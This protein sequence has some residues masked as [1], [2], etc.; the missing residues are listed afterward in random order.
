M[1]HAAETKK[2]S[3]SRKTQKNSPQPIILTA[4]PTDRPMN[5]D[6]TNYARKK[7]THSRRTIKNKE[8]P[9]PSLLLLLQHPSGLSLTL[10][11]AGEAGN[12]GRVS[13]PHLL[14][15]RESKHFS[16]GTKNNHQKTKGPNAKRPGN[17]EKRTNINPKAVGRT[18]T[19]STKTDV[20]F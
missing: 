13:L 14:D 4:V 12:G 5:K 9:P 6:K 18:A 7:C 2:S 19:K 3:F 15:R 10:A 16:R 20:A 11:G 17:E 1:H 8:T